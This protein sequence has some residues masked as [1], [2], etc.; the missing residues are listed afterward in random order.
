MKLKKVRPIL[1]FSLDILITSRM[2]QLKAFKYVAEKTD[3]EG[4][5]S[6]T[7]IGFCEDLVTAW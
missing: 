7:G 5:R 3:D 1:L 6:V 4:Y 2:E